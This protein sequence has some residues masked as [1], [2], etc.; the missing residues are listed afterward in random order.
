MDE[1]LE[2]VG[3]AILDRFEECFEYVENE[4]YIAST[5]DEAENYVRQFLGSLKDYEVQKVTFTDL[6]NDFGCSSLTYAMAPAAFNRF[7]AIAENRNVAFITERRNMF[8]EIFIDLKTDKSYETDEYS[9][10]DDYL[11]TDD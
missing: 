3:Y 8:D 1:D 7:K 9:D 5:K 4:C 6:Q 11:D 10:I 2:L